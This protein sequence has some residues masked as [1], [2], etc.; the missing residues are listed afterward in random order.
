MNR[1]ATLAALVSCLVLGSAC[2]SSA[3]ATRS[4]PGDEPAGDPAQRE[5]PL[6]TLSDGWRARLLLDN[7]EV[8]IWTVE[9]LQVFPQYASPEVVALDDA[10]RCHVLVSYSGKWTPVT[11]V[12]DGKW[13]GG[14]AH[15]DVDPR[16]P[17]NELYVG[18]QSGNLYQLVP[19]RSGVIDNRLIATFEGREVHTVVGGELDPRS[20]GPELLVFTRPGGLYRVAP[21]G[22]HG[23]FTA[24]LLEEL[25]GRVRDAELLPAEPGRPPEIA[26]VARSGALALLSIGVDGPRWT[27]VHEGPMGSGRIALRAPSAPGE[28]VVLY[29]SLDDGRILRHERRG[30]QWHSE[31]IYAGPQGPRGLAAGRFDADPA[32][33]TLAV[34]GYSGFVQLL[35]RRGGAWELETLFEDRDKGHWL[36]TAELDGRNA[37]DEIIG[38]GYG[39]RVFL[40]QRP[41]GYGAAGLLVD[42]AREP[43]SAGGEARS[44]SR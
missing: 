14:I 18:S 37:T 7:G 35:S 41:P 24:E 39:A 19:Y 12:H 1:R 36:A 17:G 4:E 5:V 43:E 3:R 15:G 11:R 28:P 20:E 21:R 10:G 2:A 25:P 44:T 30:A 23:T 27:T 9:A 40:L 34:F 38:S 29:S 32:V 31:T 13:L 22:E 16:I 6:A 8:G 26:T 33:E 42:P